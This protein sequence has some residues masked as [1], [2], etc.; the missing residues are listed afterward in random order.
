MKCYACGYEKGPVFRQKY[1]HAVLY[2]SG[3]RKGQVKGTEEREI[4]LGEDQPEF[5]KVSPSGPITMEVRARYEDDP[6]SDANVFIQIYACPKCGTL[7]V[8][9]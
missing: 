3:P 7:K 6:W 5:V 8:R 9:E 1:T 2:K 4:V